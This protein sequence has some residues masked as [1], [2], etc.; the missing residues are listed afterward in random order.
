MN[1]TTMIAAAGAVAVAGMFGAYRLGQQSPQAHTAA[2]AAKEER[3]VLY[4]QDP[5]VPGTRFDKPGKSPYMDMDLVPVYADEQPQ[6]GGVR[7]APGVRQN[8]GVR[9]VQVREGALRSGLRVVGNVA[10]NERERVLVQAR[11]AGFV[12]RLHARAP[13][14]AVRKGQP[15][16]ELYVPDWVAAQEE[17]LAVRRMGDVPAAA[18]LLDAARQRMRLAGMTEDQVRQVAASGKVQARVTVV[19]P[20]AGIISELGA[21]EGMTV[22][23]GAPLVT[24]SG[25]SS[26]WLNAEVPE[27]A[28]AQVRPGTAVT[29]TTPAYPGETFHGKVEALLPQVDPSTRTLAARIALANRDNKLS[30]GM[31]ASVDVSAGAARQALLVPSEAVI[32]TGE[33]SVVIVSDGDKFVPAEVGV[34]RESGG[35]TE[36]L[37]GLKAGQKVVASGQFMI[38]SEASLRGTV[39]RMGEGTRQ[40]DQQASAPAALHKASGKVEKIAAGEVVISHGPVA[41]LDWGAMTMGFAPPPSG[42]AGGVRV[43]DTISF[44]F[45]RGAQG[46]FELVA[47]RREAG[48][49]AP[50]PT[51]APKP[52]P[53]PAPAGAAQPAPHDP[54]AGHQMPAAPEH[55]HGGAE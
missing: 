8:L 27:G 29:A 50:A 51:P 33:R 20:A 38:D 52:A 47:V 34:G 22:A 42:L 18:G 39:R 4:W 54:H 11:S 53:K 55:V 45:K 40:P 37:S 14:E 48:A 43:G 32:R 21:R 26:V 1:R 12:E 24:I 2:P 17:Y 13:L 5:M 35:E 44:E 41:S 25:L 19:A 7:I 49:Q 9:L 46:G 15:L 10:F 28:A 30:P 36:I 23:A 6:D 16:L 31:F 3:K